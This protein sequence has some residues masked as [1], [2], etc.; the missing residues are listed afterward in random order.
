MIV[1]TVDS[2]EV[3]P[4]MMGALVTRLAA[5]HRGDHTLA[6]RT[7]QGQLTLGP[8][9]LLDGSEACLAALSELG[10]VEVV[11]PSSPI[12]S[13]GDRAADDRGNQSCPD[14]GTT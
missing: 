5:E 1:V 11:D 7:A 14:G 4:S 10:T 8:A 6:I 13:A 12:R 3:A 2:R 9:W